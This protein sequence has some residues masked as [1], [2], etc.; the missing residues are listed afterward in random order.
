MF[1]ASAGAVDNAGGN[2]I[3]YVMVELDKEIVYDWGAS[4]YL[5]IG[6]DTYG[7]DTFA[8]RSPESGDYSRVVSSLTAAGTYEVRSAQVIDLS[9]NTTA[10][11]RD[12]LAAL[13]FDTGFKITGS[14]GD[15]IKPVL[16]GL[17]VPTYLDLS[18][19]TQPY[20]FTAQAGDEGGAGVR[21]VWV[22]LDRSFVTP[23]R[24]KQGILFLNSTPEE[25]DFDDATP[26]SAVQFEQI[27]P[28]T[29]HGAYNISTVW[30]EDGAGNR[31]TYDVDQLRDMGIA[32][33]FQA[34]DG[35]TLKPPTAVATMRL[36]GDNVIV[37]MS[38]QAWKS[39][40]GQANISLTYD[41]ARM[42][43]LG[44]TAPGA[45][46]LG[47]EANSS[48]DAGYVSTW[49]YGHTTDS[50][51]VVSMTFK[52]LDTRSNVSFNLDGFSI[53][54]QKQTFRGGELLKFQ[55]GGA[56]DDLLRGGLG[57]D[58]TDGGAGYDTVRYA[59]SSSGIEITRSANG[60]TVTDGKG[61]YDDL[62]NVEVIAF[63]DRAIAYDPEG[64]AGD[65]FRL[66]QAAFDRTPDKPGLGYW[67]D[68]AE[69]GASLRSIAAGF[70][71]SAEFKNM[72]GTGG[73]DS[74][75]LEKLYQHALH[76]AP[77]EEG[78]LYWQHQLHRGATRVDLLLSFADS[79][80]NHAQVIGSIRDGIDYVPIA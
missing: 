28:T 47:G 70:M 44:A 54:T 29:P 80:E 38:A 14:Q 27:M 32:T 42:H 36:D 1:H 26:G 58:A 2:G 49:I 8:D 23:D 19:G 48:T 5:F 13:G 40:D 35:T 11:S 63:T 3:A 64:T 46:I 77:D 61:V 75:F 6:R 74:V 69:H 68:K 76:R 79:P 57:N 51:E 73:P 7:L 12:Q 4:P 60:F 17:Q 78:M 45:G 43:Y 56:G 41:P 9:G 10:Y 22:Y 62:L 34:G 59:M 39:A 66:Y 31:A 33:R 67:I 65:I 72:Y 20:A 55:H 25:D 30:V 71:Q 50:P 52:L 37:T 16:K 21:Q 15:T 24:A 53:G 18:K